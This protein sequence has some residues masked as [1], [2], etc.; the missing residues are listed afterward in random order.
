MW[1]HLHKNVLFLSHYT[2]YWKLVPILKQYCHFFRYITEI[3]HT[4]T[5]VWSGMQICSMN[6]RELNFGLTQFQTRIIESLEHCDA[7]NHPV[8]QLVHDNLNQHLG[9][10]N[11]RISWVNILDLVFYWI[12]YWSLHKYIVVLHSI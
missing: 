11:A 3:L 12:L 8:L 4:L 1:V 7:A 9:G 6:F 2:R 10:I 5:S